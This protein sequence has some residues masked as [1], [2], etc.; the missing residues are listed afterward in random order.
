VHKAFSRRE[1]KRNV[2][3]PLPVGLLS[4]S[5]D[6]DIQLARGYMIFYGKMEV[7]GHL[8]KLSEVGP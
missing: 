1:W 3:L 4:G 8:E 5:L 2:S 7:G 6:G